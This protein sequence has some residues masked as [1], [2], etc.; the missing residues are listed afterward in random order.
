MPKCFK[1]TATYPIQRCVECGEAFCGWHRED[2]YEENKV[3][4]Y[5]KGCYER[6]NK[7]KDRKTI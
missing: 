5:C 1:C 6:R 2:R 7:R 4:R 3:K